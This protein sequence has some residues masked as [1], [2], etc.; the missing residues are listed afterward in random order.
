MVASVKTKQA[1]TISTAKANRLY[2]LGRY[3]ERVYITLHFLRK[4]S[5][6]MIDQ[7]PIAYREFC[8]KLGVDDTRYTAESFLHNFLYDK[9]NPESLISMLEIA[10]GNGMQLREEI[11]TET[12]SYIEMSIVQMYHSEKAKEG[13]LELQSITDSLLA[14]WGSIDVRV[15]NFHARNIIKMG[16]FIESMDLHLRFK[17]PLSKITDTYMMLKEN[18]DNNQIVCNLYNL[19]LLEAQLNEDDFREYKTLSLVNNLFIA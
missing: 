7:N 5:D 17:Y 10:K 15:N 4:N 3:V 6:L 1:G 12:L 18:T 13:L 16:R 9:N 19:R 14:F 11:M 8:K 2:W